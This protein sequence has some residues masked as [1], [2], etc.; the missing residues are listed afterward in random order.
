MAYGEQEKVLEALTL[1]RIQQ[2]LCQRGNGSY[3]WP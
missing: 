2:A 3:S 1:V